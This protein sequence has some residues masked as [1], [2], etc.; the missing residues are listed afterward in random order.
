MP[1]STFLVQAKACP[2]YEDTSIGN[3]NVKQSDGST[4]F[5]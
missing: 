4:G 3:D 1:V 2:I 5:F